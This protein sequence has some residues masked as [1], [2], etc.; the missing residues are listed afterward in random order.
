MPTLYSPS[1]R[2]LQDRFDSRRLAD[3]L[4]K[5]KVHDSITVDDRAFIE[6]QDMCFMAT[7]DPQGQPTCSYKGGAPGFVVV[8]DEHTLAMPNYDGN[9]MYLS[10][11]NVEA[12]ERVGLL[13]IDFVAQRRIR[14][15]GAAEL[16]HDDALLRRYPGAQFML[17]LHVER[18]YPNCGRYIHQMARVEPSA[19]VPDEHGAAPVPGWKRTDWARDV[20]PAPT[21]PPRAEDR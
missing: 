13:F 20:L 10:M 8:L 14:V 2:A 15:E 17:Y 11:G 21:T 7:V 5:V 4:E 1:A 16:R 9:G 6:Q 19:F 12:T 3:R 18:V